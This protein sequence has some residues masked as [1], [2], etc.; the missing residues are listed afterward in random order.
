MHWPQFAAY[1]SEGLLDLFLI[2]NVGGPEN[3]TLSRCAKS[4]TDMFQRSGV[5]RQRHDSETFLGEGF[6][7][8]R[9]NAWSDAG[10]NCDFLVRHVQ[11]S[12]LSFLESGPRQATLDLR[13][14]IA[15][16]LAMLFLYPF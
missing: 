13:N 11:S 3:A 5:A 7:N 15:I 4:H 1:T 10:H 6:H 14:W 9:T 2:S 8:A 12:C 16:V